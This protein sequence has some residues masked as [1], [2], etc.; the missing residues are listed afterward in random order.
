[1]NNI[2]TNNIDVLF[3]E[4]A[5]LKARISSLEAEIYNIKFNNNPWIDQHIPVYGPQ[6]YKVDTPMKI[7]EYTWTCN[8][9]IPSTTGYS[10]MPGI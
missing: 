8:T 6:Y 3:N 4:I 5:A 7:T 2:E 1:M 9:A 10:N